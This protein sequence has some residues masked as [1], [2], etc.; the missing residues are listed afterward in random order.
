MPSGEVVFSTAWRLPK[1]VQTQGGFTPV[2]ANPEDHRIDMSS[3]KSRLGLVV[4]GLDFFHRWVLNDW[5]ST[6]I[7][8]AVRCS[9]PGPISPRGRVPDTP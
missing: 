1:I 7:N 2:I 4:E 3:M 8:A 5:D 9:S 6:Q